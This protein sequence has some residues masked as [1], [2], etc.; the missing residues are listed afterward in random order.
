MRHRHAA[1]ALAAFA[2]LLAS[3]AFADD[4]LPDG[5][6]AK[7]T[8]TG[9][10]Q[11]WYGRPTDRYDHGVLGDAIEG[12][13]L[14]VVDAAGERRELV[15]PDRYVFEDITPRLVDL[16]GDGQ[17]EVVA[18]RTDVAAGAAVVVYRLQ[19]GALT[20]WASTPPI[21]SPRRW[22]S[23]AAIADF[24]GDGRLEIA[25]VKTPHIGG[26]LDLLSLE[27]NR[28][29]SLYAPQGGYST[30]FIGSRNLSLATTGDLTGDGLAELILPDQAR[31]RV[32]VLSL[33]DGVETLLVQDLPARVDRPMHVLAPRRIAVPIETGETLRLD[34]PQDLSS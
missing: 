21:G 17:N 32:I 18:I 26:S 16:D 4:R 14:V 34:V 15:L 5:G 13:S 25:V 27:Q 3:A 29:V 24:T 23:I 2:S 10:V 28:L 31:R 30:H 9:P 33:V 22:L 1:I 8:G 12:G 19:A 11:A 6:V 20:E 7:A